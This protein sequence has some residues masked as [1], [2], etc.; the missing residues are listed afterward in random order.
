MTDQPADAAQPAQATAPNLHVLT[1]YVR[2]LSFE[3]P[4]APESLVAGW[5]A[6]ETGVQITL[7]HKVVQEDTYDVTLHLRVEAKKKGEDK[8]VFIVD[9]VYGALV[10][11]RGIP[12]EQHAPAI[13]V[14][15]PKLL[16]PF[17]R[18]I[19]ATTTARGGYPPLYLAPISFE[20]LYM[21]EVQRLRQQQEQQSAGNA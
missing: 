6:P 9:L 3:N 14:E 10:Q 4:H 16:F 12:R 7:Q 11:L 1:Q 21:Q 19:I 5:G 8:K 20:S 15:V 17:A 18:E 13:M 2:D